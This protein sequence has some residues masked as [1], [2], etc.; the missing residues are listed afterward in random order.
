MCTHILT[1]TPT[2]TLTISPKGQDNWLLSKSPLWLLISS[3]GQPWCVCARILVRP[4]W[5]RINVQHVRLMKL[6]CHV[7]FHAYRRSSPL[8]CRH[9]DAWCHSPIYRTAALAPPVWALCACVCVCVGGWVCDVVFS[10]V[11][12]F[13]TL[14][15]IIW[16]NLTALGSPMVKLASSLRL[17]SP[18][19]RWTD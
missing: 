9:R 5:T 1:H 14:E 18:Q 11:G 12:F 13:F 2:H 15:G 3:C 7:T 6:Q 4:R 19:W 16:G 10:V 17:C 8:M